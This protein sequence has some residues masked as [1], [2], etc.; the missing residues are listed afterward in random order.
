MDNKA[1]NLIGR[2]LLGGLFMY[3]SIDKIAFPGE[4]AVRIQAYGILSPVLSHI[5]ALLIPWAELILGI[6][7]IAGIFIKES[8]LSL[9]ILLLIFI[10]ATFLKPLESGV[11]DCGCFGGLPFLS[12]SN[13]L[14]MIGRNLLF[15]VTGLYVFLNRRGKNPE[16]KYEG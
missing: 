14:I 6:F 10:I 11:E 5:A 12:T 3:A 16:R 1:V 2:F 4:F 9:S 7:L 8:A 15:L 13:R